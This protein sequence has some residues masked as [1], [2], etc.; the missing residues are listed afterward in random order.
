VCSRGSPVQTAIRNCTRDEGGSFEAGSQVL[1]SNRCKLLSS[2]S[3]VAAGGAGSEEF[4]QN[5]ATEEEEQR[6]PGF[7]AKNLYATSPVIFDSA[8]AA[9]QI[10]AAAYTQASGKQPGWIA[11]GADSSARVLIEA[12]ENSEENSE[13]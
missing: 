2:S 11:A 9:A 5:F 3:V 12:K 10:F 1:A 13:K 4:L 8:G 6:E 7:F